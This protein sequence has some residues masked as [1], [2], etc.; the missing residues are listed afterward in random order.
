MQSSPPTAEVTSYRVN[1]ALASCRATSA[2]MRIMETL[3][4]QDANKV[5]P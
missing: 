4:Q 2:R 5:V 1:S 3:L